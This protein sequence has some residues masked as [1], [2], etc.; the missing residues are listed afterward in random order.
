MF[1]IYFALVSALS[2]ADELPSYAMA[3][4]DGDFDAALRHAQR[5][6][7]PDGA[8]GP[9]VSASAPACLAMADAAL[10]LGHEVD[11]DEHFRRAQKLLV[12]H[13][14]L[15]VLSCRNTGWQ[16]LSLHR[17]SA[18]MQCFARVT[19]DGAASARQK[20]EAVLGVA[21]IHH[22]LGQQAAC[23]EA[24]G[25]ARA[26]AADDD[27]ARWALLVD[28]LALDCAVQLAVRCSAG[29]RDHVFWQPGAAGADHQLLLGRFAAAMAA[30]DAARPAPELAAQRHGC[31]ALLLRLADGERDAMLALQRHVDQSRRWNCLSYSSGVHV[32]IA[33]AALAG[34]QP[35]LAEQT[36][37]R[38]QRADRRALRWSL[39]QRYCQ[40]KIAMLKGDAAD[41]LRFY[42][43][44][45]SEALQCLRSETQVIKALHGVVREAVGQPSDDISARLP[46]KYRRAYRYIVDNYRNND[47]STGEIA[48][49]IG[50]TE[51]A[52][53]LAFRERLG[54][55]P[56]AVLRRLRLDAVRAELMTE[57]G[58]GE[59]ILKTANRLGL[60]SRSS[61]IRGY[62]KQFNEA[63]SASAC[64]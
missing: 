23:D 41:A 3:M 11:A 50:V 34:G 14:A 63:P 9:G 10:L 59:G 57:Q 20:V 28:L 6:A 54:M 60:K 27:D 44:Y 52:L 7:G 1:Q 33:L 15:R 22:Q 4:Q 37:Q 29:L 40:A 61:L 25:H 48:A 49:H 46:A 47:L 36:L 35:D 2:Q 64:R 32:E 26:L 43:G 45:T 8:A 38:G 21:L 12:S 55:S 53:Q 5:A 18:A 56:T 51:R 58:G 31:L 17:Y 62:R 19:Q 30:Q 16:A 13:D 42:A 39:D 24:L